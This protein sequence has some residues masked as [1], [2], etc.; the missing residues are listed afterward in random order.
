MVDNTPAIY[1]SHSLACHGRTGYLGSRIAEANTL[2]NKKWIS[3]EYLET[4]EML[5]DI[6]TKPVTPAVMNYL[7]PKI[8]KK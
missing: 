6:L 1:L 3:F 4:K 5:A 8:L 2:V 7:V